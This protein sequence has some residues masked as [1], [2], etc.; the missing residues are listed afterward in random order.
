MM[1]KEK[2][3]AIDL[4]IEGT[5]TKTEI[6]KQCGRSRQWL[7]EILERE[8]VKAEI[9]RRLRQ[10][11]LYGENN[12]K[13]TMQERINNIVKLANTA[14]SEKVRLDSNIYLIDRVLGKTT[15]KV[16][17]ITEITKDTVDKDV[18]T[19]ELKEELKEDNTSE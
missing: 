13:A 2:L 12:L 6:A 18:L 7:Y 19:I 16:E 17:D 4:L 14:D 11:K 3:R 9:D 5:T 15:T 10:I 1:N 8:E